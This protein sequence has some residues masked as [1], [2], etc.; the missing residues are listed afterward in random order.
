M[1][2]LASL[3]SLFILAIVLENEAVV[4][5]NFTLWVKG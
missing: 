4:N 5:I 2:A 3:V 1:R